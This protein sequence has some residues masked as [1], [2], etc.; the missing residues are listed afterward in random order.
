LVSAIL[1]NGLT[2]RK[3]AV[4]SAEAACISTPQFTLGPGAALAFNHTGQLKTISCDLITAEER[5][6]GLNLKK[7]INRGGWAGKLKKKARAGKGNGP[8]SSYFYPISS[9]EHCA[10]MT[11]TSVPTNRW[12]HWLL[13]EPDFPKERLIGRQTGNP[14]AFLA[15]KKRF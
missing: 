9:Q 12:S 2:G 7:I 3:P 4:L 1:D 10:D 5:P 6:G 15:T 13:S 11:F 14:S 8:I